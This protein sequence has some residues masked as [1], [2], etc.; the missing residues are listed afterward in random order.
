MEFPIIPHSAIYLTAVDFH[1]APKP[2]LAGFLG[3]TF[4]FFYTTCGMDIQTSCM[5][6]FV[7]VELLVRLLFILWILFL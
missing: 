2:V 5:A 4:M 1:N 6:T 7:F 3:S